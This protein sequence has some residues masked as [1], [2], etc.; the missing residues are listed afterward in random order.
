MF[1]CVCR[2]VTDRDI[3]EAVDNGVQHVEQLGELCGVGT[4][5]G[6]CT[7]MAQELI[8]TRLGEN[9]AYAAA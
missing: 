8:E 4:G 5:C 2:A 9:Q 7:A 1:V 6:S 3:E